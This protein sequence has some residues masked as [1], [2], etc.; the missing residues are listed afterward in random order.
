MKYAARAVP[1]AKYDGTNSE[2]IKALFINPWMAV[3]FEDEAEVDG[4]YTFTA[5]Y[6]MDGGYHTPFSISED[7]WLVFEGLWSVSVLDDA[8]F[9]SRFILAE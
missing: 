9:S 4:T 2:E 5:V 6:D 1:V 8:A 3:T 7:E